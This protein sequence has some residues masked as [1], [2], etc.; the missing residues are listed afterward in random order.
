MAVSDGTTSNTAYVDV[1]T[2]SNVT[3][4]SMFDQNS[5]GWTVINVGPVTAP[6]WSATAAGTIAWNTAAV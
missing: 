5:Q 2:R 1:T 4:Q 3:V 6:I